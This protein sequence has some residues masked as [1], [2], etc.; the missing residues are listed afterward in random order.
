[1]PSRRCV[2]LR[3]MRDA[4]KEAAATAEPSG[5]Q[6]T[7][8]GP[9]WTVPNILRAFTQA[10]P[11][12][13]AVLHSASHTT[14]LSLRLPSPYHGR[15]LQ[16]VPRAGAE[17][18][19]AHT[20]G[21]RPQRCSFRPTARAAGRKHTCLLLIPCFHGAAGGSS[22]TAPGNPMPT[23]AERETCGLQP[24]VDTVLQTMTSWY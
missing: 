2:L 9:S 13:T 21:W 23:L 14:P 7:N 18:S 22:E 11:A 3:K 24:Q 4:T 12:F 15:V 8:V 10:R 5:H 19:P 17:W 20:A 16:S 6:T 1:V